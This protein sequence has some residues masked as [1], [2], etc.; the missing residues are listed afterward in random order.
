MKIREYTE[1][2]ASTAIYPYRGQFGGLSYVI[3]GLAGETGECFE[4][5]KKILRDNGGIIGDTSR[6]KSEVGD[7]LWYWSQLLFETQS[8]FKEDDN[9][10]ADAL[11]RNVYAEYLGDHDYPDL[12][13]PDYLYQQIFILSQNHM[14]ISKMFESYN[15]IRS[16]ED[17]NEYL[18]IISGYAIEFY[19]S[20]CI[21][22]ANMNIEISEVMQMNLDK[23]AARKD[24][25]K[26]QGS[27]ETIDER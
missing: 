25:G 11:Q 8:C 21:L 2:S 16:P 12:T 26:L 7:I 19:K 23:L 5:L 27:G 20:I 14:W 17:C 24:A 18:P 13:S 6:I 4:V 9:T 1:K 10:V 22:L 15:S 3:C